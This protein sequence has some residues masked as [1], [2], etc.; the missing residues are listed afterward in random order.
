VRV[1][2]VSGDDGSVRV[3]DV[4]GDPVLAV[5]DGRVDADGL[6]GAVEV[7]ADDGEATLG[8]VGRLTGSVDDGRI[9]TREATTL[10]D[11]RA[12]D[13]ELDLLVDGL[14]GDATVRSDDG[15]V[16]LALSPTLDATVSIT[17][18]DGSLS[19]EGDLFETVETS[20][21][22]TRGTLGTGRHRLTVSTDDGSVT[23]RPLGDG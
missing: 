13:G 6:A 3:R 19:V 22:T 4:A 21:G 9:R 17:V 16:R 7:S 5:D 1:D 12:D 8:A 15:R 11:V 14:D 23:V 10:G 20:A 2:R 18:D